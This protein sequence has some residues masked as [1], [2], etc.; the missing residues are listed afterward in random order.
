ME[1]PIKQQIVDFIT[2]N[3]LFVDTQTGLGEEDSL[4]ETGVI[5]STGVLEI[6]AFIEETYGIKVE[7]EE[8]IPDNLN[9][10]RDITYFVQQKLS[11]RVVESLSC[12][13]IES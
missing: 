11:R 13:V 5:D 9:T 6:V 1:R 8:L 3:F 2:T 10:I 7:D 4:L 12:R